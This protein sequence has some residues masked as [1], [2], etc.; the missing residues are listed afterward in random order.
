MQGGDLV[1][2][3]P[4]DDVHHDGGAVGQ[5]VVTG[6]GDDGG[7]DQGV[8]RPILEFYEAESAVGIVPLDG[9]LN[10][11]A[12]DDGLTVDV[13]ARGLTVHETH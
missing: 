4:L 10:L 2:L 7:G 5:G 13:L 9:G 8:G 6:G 12:E 3:A 11:G 1:A